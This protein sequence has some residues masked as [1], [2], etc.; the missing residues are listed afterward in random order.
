MFFLFW[1]SLAD[2]KKVKDLEFLTNDLFSRV[3]RLMI[4]KRF[5]I[6]LLLKRGL[7]FREVSESLK[8]S[9]NTVSSVAKKIKRS[10]RGYRQLLKRFLADK[11]IKKMVDSF[12]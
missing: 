9:P 3:E 12:C 2:I 8:V 7:S 11:K 10:T 5:M 4:A 6:A 1:K